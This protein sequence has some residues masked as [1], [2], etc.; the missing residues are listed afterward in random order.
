MALTAWEGQERLEQ[1]LLMTQ[2]LKLNQY[3][4]NSVYTR[5]GQNSTPNSNA[6]NLHSSQKRCCSFC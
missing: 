2:L 5:S 1:R 3:A 4:L 6:T